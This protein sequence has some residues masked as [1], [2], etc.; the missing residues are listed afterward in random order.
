MTVTV[1]AGD[2][3]MKTCVLCARGEGWTK[4]APQGLDL[5]SGPMCPLRPSARLASIRHTRF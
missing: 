5:E 2:P 3:A 4:V 1:T